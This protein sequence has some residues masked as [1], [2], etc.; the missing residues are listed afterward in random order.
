MITHG[1]GCLPDPPHPH[2]QGRRPLV[3]LVGAS[4]V[5]PEA[6][7]GIRPWCPPVSD[8]GPEESCVAFATANALYARQWIDGDLPEMPSRRA[9]WYWA[10]SIA[11]TVSENVGTSPTDLFNAMSVH[12]YP[13]ERVWGL[14]RRFDERPDQEAMLDA[15]DQRDVQ[16][17]RLAEG[18][19]DLAH[20]LSAT[21]HQRFP[22]TIS[23]LV[24]RAYGRTTSSTW[25]RDHV[26]EGWHRVLAAAFIR[27]GVWTLGS[28]GPGHGA[29]GYVLVPWADIM[30]PARCRDPWAV[31]FTPAFVTKEAA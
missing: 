13:P 20:D 8:Q 17:A 28:Y 9:L 22:V 5:P 14:E 29:N 24:D 11:G 16:C 3:D 18:G 27:E 6:S 10:R 26:D 23:L 15:A 4:I 25:A 7:E 1:R 30:S 2:P 12:G 31:R 19:E 21:L